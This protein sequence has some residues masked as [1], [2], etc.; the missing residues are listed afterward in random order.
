MC[1]QIKEMYRHL[2][3]WVPKDMH[4]IDEYMPQHS[5]IH[6]HPME[7]T[8]D[9]PPAEVGHSGRSR[10]SKAHHDNTGAMRQIEGMEAVTKEAV[11]RNHGDSANKAVFEQMKAMVKEG[12]ADAKDVP[13]SFHAFRMRLN[14]RAKKQTETTQWQHARAKKQK[15]GVSFDDVVEA[16][17]GISNVDVAVMRK[18]L[19]NMNPST[20][21][22]TL[23]RRR[24]AAAREQ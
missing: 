3:K 24:D 15:Q 19:P 16:Q 4:D 12:T 11:R 20:L 17:G 10:H 8:L 6:L 13:N 9:T 22:V 23:K 1:T 7:E 2:R 18:M 21:R 14:R 5:A